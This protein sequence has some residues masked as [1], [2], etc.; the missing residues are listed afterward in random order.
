MK[1][2]KCGSENVIVQAVAEHKKRGCLMA[3][4]WIFLAI[5]TLGAI[6]WI[7]L[8]M[9]KGSKTVTYA[10]CQTCGNRWMV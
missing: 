5:C 3:V 2:P 8:L 4:L 7:P 10:I 1:C 9:R 6:I